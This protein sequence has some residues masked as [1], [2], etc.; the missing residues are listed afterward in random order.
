MKRFIAYLKDQR[1]LETLEWIL[2]GGF[3]AGIAAL[4]FTG[5]LKDALSATMD[6]IVTAVKGK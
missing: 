4:F 6:A 2:V 5:A 1:G 3:V